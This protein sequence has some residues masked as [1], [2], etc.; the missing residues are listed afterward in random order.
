M[1]GAIPGQYIVSLSSG[2]SPSTMTAR[3]GVKPMYTYTRAHPGFAARLTPAQLDVIR[4]QPGVEA[5]EQ[6]ATVTMPRDM[7]GAAPARPG[8]VTKVAEVPWNLSRI[9]G[10]E[11]GRVG[12]SVKATGAK[13]RAYI[14]DSGIELEH[15][16]FGGRAVAGAGFVDDG[17][18]ARDCAGHGTHVAGTVGGARSGVAKRTTLVSVRVF[19]CAGLTTNSTVIAAVNWVAE[20][21]R[22]PAVANLSMGGPRSAAV[23]RAVEDLAGAGVF[24]VVAAGNSDADACTVS[25]AAARSGFTVGAVDRRDRRAPFSNWGRC[26]KINAPGVD[27]RSAHLKGTFRELSGT[28]AAAPHVT[29]VAALYKDARGDAPYATLASWLTRN[30]TGGMDTSRSGAPTGTP[31]LL[32]STGDL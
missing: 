11:A 25:P 7:R 15:P 29:G 22:P 27:I 19:D 17:R 9:D 23:D 20:H 12:Y 5:V 8:P 21:A 10:R 31:P 30:A 18:G 13:V 32:V 24:P 28:S 14:I 2:V 16:E 3:A 4:D 6:D 1:A 26:V